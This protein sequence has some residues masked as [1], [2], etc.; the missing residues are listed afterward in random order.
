MTDIAVQTRRRPDVLT[1]AIFIAALVLAWDIVSASHTPI[2]SLVREGN[3]SIMR[4][5]SVREW[6][7]GSGWFD[8]TIDR[9]LPPDG[10]SLHWSRYFDIGIAGTIRAL[11]LVLPADRAEAV[12][13]VLWPT[14]LQMAF[15]AVTGFAAARLCGRL[16]AAVAI[17]G[18]LTW[19]LTGTVYFGPL[20]IDHHGMQI[21]LSAVV[22]FCLCTPS[23]SRWPGLAAGLAAALSLAIGLETLPTIGIAGTILVLRGLVAPDRGVGQ[24]TGFGASLGPATLLLYA[25]QTPRAEWLMSRCDELGPAIL[26]LAVAGSAAALL[27]AIVA[28]RM[29]QMRTRLA[30]GAVVALCT[31]AVC[32]PALSSCAGGPYADLPE[33]L[34]LAISTWIPEARPAQ[35]YIGLTN[36]TFFAF[37]LP[38]W[39]TTTVAT[40][41]LLSG[42]AWRR[43]PDTA[44]RA[45]SVLLI[46][47]WLG[48]A[49][50]LVQL[51]LLVL[52]APV[53]PA[54]MGYI[55][56]RLLTTET[57]QNR[58]ASTTIA[59]LLCLVVLLLPGQ[60][61]RALLPALQ[62]GGPAEA[63][64]IRP[65]VCRDAGIVESLDTLPPSR[66]M[67]TGNLDRPVLLLT[68]HTVLGSPYHRSATALRNAA[69]SREPDE[70]VVRAMLA[71]SRADY[72]VLCRGA[73]YSDGS[74]FVNRLAAGA[75]LPGFTPVD[76]PDP[77][78]L[79]LRVEP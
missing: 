42:A 63:A 32:L 21:L 65:S 78:L 26:V 47:A 44:D 45:A 55:A 77:A 50:S 57:G 54:L 71:E 46:F 18:A 41:V 19:L 67:T 64:P 31:S 1:L 12:A 52:A 2:E 75:I 43:A 8:T 6:M 73:R 13:I 11:S 16:A 3:D 20:K 7:A 59:A 72:L 5:V 69:I 22:I 74:G 33:D 27:V 15:L 30:F 9:V 29:A 62:T 36:Q 58:S 56:N 24:L 23:D 4:L 40:I 17:L 70:T 38:A 34:R 25:G 35:S 51:R 39:A 48:V 76:G 61:H 49:G 28:P 10:L 53:V 60:I 68:H 14:F 79:V 37:V 66:L